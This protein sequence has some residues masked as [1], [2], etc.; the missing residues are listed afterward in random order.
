MR[1]AVDLSAGYMHQY[2]YRADVF[3]LA[4]DF[5]SG[6]YGDYVFFQASTYQY[7]ILYDCQNLQVS[8]NAVTADSASVYQIDVTTGTG[9]ATDLRLSGSLS[10]LGSFS[11]SVVDSSQLCAFF[12]SAENVSVSNS[13]D[14][15]FYS[16]LSD[17]PELV[18]GGEHYAFAQVLLLAIFGVFVLIDIIF[19]RVYR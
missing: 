7:V 5:V 13:Y 1:P 12:Y 2:I 3:T 8:Q 16:S 4:H 9:Y 10:G 14:S 15:A 17:L 6:M 11:G 18:E 19:R